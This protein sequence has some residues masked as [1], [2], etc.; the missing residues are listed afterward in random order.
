MSGGCREASVLR[1][2]TVSNAEGNHSLQGY[3]SSRR[4]HETFTDIEIQLLLT[5]LC[6]SAKGGQ[7]ISPG[8]LIRAVHLLKAGRIFFSNMQNRSYLAQY[9]AALSMVSES[10]DVALYPQNLGSIGS[11]PAFSTWYLAAK[12]IKLSEQ[13]QMRKDI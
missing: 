8:L 11:R 5:V 9:Q 2:R 3:F 12:W 10:Q 6:S 13:G 1:I 4:V 7:A